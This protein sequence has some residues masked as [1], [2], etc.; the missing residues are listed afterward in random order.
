M[1]SIKH[2]SLARILD[3]IIYHTSESQV[4]QAASEFDVCVIPYGGRTNVTEALECPRI[5]YPDLAYYK[6]ADSDT[7]TSDGTSL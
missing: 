3:A 4:V 7:G 5:V 2:N 1:Y 6:E